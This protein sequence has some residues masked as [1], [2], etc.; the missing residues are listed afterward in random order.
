MMNN[1]LKQ[2]L[3]GLYKMALCDN[4]FA[5]EEMAM[6][7]QVGREYGVSDEEVNQAVM[8]DTFTLYLPETIE[9]KVQLL[10]RFTQM[11]W[12]D[13]VIVDEE[14]EL[15]K[16]TAIR[17][18]FLKENTDAIVEFLIEKVKNKI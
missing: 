12:A 10:Y 4:Q 5:A 17:Y 7:Y 18:G 9:G 11:A 15:L 3:L 6:L 8:D 2:L 14:K 1:S 13:G 16:Q